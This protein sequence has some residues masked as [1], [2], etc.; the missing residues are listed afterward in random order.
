MNALPNSAK[1]STPE[2]KP[3]IECRSFVEYVGIQLILESEDIDHVLDK[4]FALEE[5]V[6]ISVHPDHYD[7]AKEALIESG[8]DVIAL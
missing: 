3:L 2:L 5:P 8:Y 7:N 1:P 6:L 4:S